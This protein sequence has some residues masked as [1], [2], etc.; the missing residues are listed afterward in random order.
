MEHLEVDAE[1]LDFGF[2]ELDLRVLDL[3]DH[4]LDIVG[5]FQ[6]FEQDLHLPHQKQL[7]IVLRRDV[8]KHVVHQ[9]FQLPELLVELHLAEDIVLVDVGQ[10]FRLL[11]SFQL[12][13]LLHHHLDLVLII[14]NHRRDAHQALQASQDDFRKRLDLMVLQELRLHALQVVFLL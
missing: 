14:A 9:R 10:L 12:L 13:L 4:F 5:A 7:I 3:V 11:A 1:H 8:G 6:L 2:G